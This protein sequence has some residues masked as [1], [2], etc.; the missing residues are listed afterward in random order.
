MNHIHIANCIHRFWFYRH[1][2]INR[3]IT[4]E[5][6]VGKC[7][8]SHI[9]LFC[10]N[11]NYVI[12]ELIILM[13]NVIWHFVLQTIWFA[14][15]SLSHC[16]NYSLSIRQNH[17]NPL[18]SITRTLL[19]CI[20]RCTCIW[21]FFASGSQ[22]WLDWPLWNICVTNDYGYVPRIVNTSW[23]FPHSWLIIEYVTRLTTTDATSGAG[24][25]YLSAASEFTPDVWWSSCYLIFSFVCMFCGF[26]FVHLSFCFLPLCCLIFFDLRCF[27]IFNLF[28]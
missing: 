14:P 17:L 2:L 24:T 13:T 9:T 19:F 22:P 7:G 8:W 26:L 1:N 23:S 4:T 16:N 15:T 6:D 5:I 21:P 25:A 3:L 11:Q 18:V 10:F 27:I 20:F 12:V 28:L